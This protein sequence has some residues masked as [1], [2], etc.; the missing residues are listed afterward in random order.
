[1]R[2]H[3]ELWL[4]LGALFLTLAAFLAATAIAYFA[5]EARYA[6]FWSPWTVTAFVSF[7]LAFGCFFGAIT[8][9]PFPPW[10][11]LQFPDIK[12]E[13]YGTSVTATEHEAASG[14]DVPAHLR[15]FTARFINA[16]TEQNAS[17]TVRLYV[18]LV[19]GSWGR[20]GEFVCPPPTWTLPPSLG[21]EPMS[22]PFA[23]PPGSAVG[24]QLVYEVPGYY[25]DKIADPLDARLEMEDHISGRRMNVR[26]EMGHHDRSTM[27]RATGGIEVLG[28]EYETQAAQHRDAGQT[29]PSAHDS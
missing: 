15:S 28:P 11:R 3:R 20:A 9:W 1:M 5:K 16:G 6:L 10:S 12:V 22:M 4:W 24:G 21:L 17:L 23:L 19:P 25:L 26:A 7:L 29:Q 2:S 8:A 18:R 27:V 14:L 13:I